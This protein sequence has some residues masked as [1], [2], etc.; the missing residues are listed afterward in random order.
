[1]RRKAND[2]FWA[3]I[4]LRIF[5]KQNCLKQGLRKKQQ[6]QS[7]WLAR[8]NQTKVRDFLRKLLERLRQLGRK[9]LE[10]K[11]EKNLEIL[12]FLPASFIVILPFF[13]LISL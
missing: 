12:F 7:R 10:K 13:P 9:F 4:C 8:L 11:L 3:T 2:S 1:M 6:E 5:Q